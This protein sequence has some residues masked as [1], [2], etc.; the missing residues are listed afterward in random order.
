MARRKRETGDGSITYQPDRKK[1]WMARISAR[2]GRKRQAKFF[3]TK[4]EAAAWLRQMNSELD[5]GTH[6]D[7]TRM[8]VN[9][10]MKTWL[11]V[12]VKPSVR[13]RTYEGYVSIHRNHISPLL[14]EIRVQALAPSDV[15]MALNKRADKGL[16]HRTLVYI[17]ATLRPA[18]KQAMLDGI[19]QRNVADAVKVPKS[20]TPP[21]EKDALTMEE[22]KRLFECCE[23]RLKIA[24]LALARTGVRIGELLALRWDDIDM[25]KK[26]VHVRRAV[27]D[28][29]TKGRLIDDPKTQSSI[30]MIPVGASVIAALQEW[31]KEQLQEKLACGS[32]WADEDNAVFTM[33]FGSRMR[34]EWVS[35]RL[36]VAAQKA[37]I[38]YISPHILR[39]TYASLLIES[40]V[41]L[42][43]VQEL[44]GHT[45]SRM[46]MEIYA[47]SNDDAKRRAADIF[48]LNAK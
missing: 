46:V 37:E 26:A 29:R 25:N 33:A 24:V 22:L 9:Q 12:Y 18:L 27:S 23:S 7:P 2:D 17:V 10:W 4:Q 1:P 48:E 39:H 5:A 38:E 6:I 36:K 14:G 47:H 45:T 41:E 19:V 16:S 28:T 8:T 40:G 32:K 20:S 21:K 15:Q 43:T 42:K 30:R 31:R 3:D 34:Q 44:M 11:E 35:R 13:L